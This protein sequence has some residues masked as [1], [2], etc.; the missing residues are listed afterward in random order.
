MIF[1]IT[2]LMRISSLEGKKV[3]VAFYTKTGT[4]KQVADIIKENIDGDIFQIQTLTPYPDDHD[5]LIGQVKK[6][7]KN[8][9]FPEIVSK[10]DIANYGVIFVGSPCWW[11]R[12]SCPVAT[13]LK[14]S[15]F[16]GKI[17]IPFVTHGGS[18][19]AFTV[20]DIKKYAPGAKV[21]GGAAFGDK[22]WVRQFQR[23][24]VEHWLNGIN[25]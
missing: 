2:S 13:F 7:L 6:E 12:L 23:S 22:R 17:I 25:L 3:L 14:S 8:E 24:E 20:N 16:S 4:T 1:L 15:N 9:N 19:I 21:L 18:G 10:G 5:M 11:S